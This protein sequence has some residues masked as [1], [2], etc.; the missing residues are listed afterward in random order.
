MIIPITTT[1]PMIPAINPQLAGSVVVVGVGIAVVTGRVA[2][3][4]DEAD[5]TGEDGAGEAAG[6]REIDGDGAGAGV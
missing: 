5:T 3:A 4:E 6:E 1:A 2:A